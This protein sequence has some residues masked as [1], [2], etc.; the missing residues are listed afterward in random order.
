MG[1]IIEIDELKSIELDILK[2]VAKFCDENGLTYYL[3]Y[4]TLIG[5]VRHKGFIPWD[6]DIDIWM[7]RKD[8]N[9]LIETFNEKMSDT[10]YIAIYPYHEEAQH[11][12][13]KIGD[14]RTIKFEPEYK[15]KNGGGYIDIDVLPLDGT[16]D[17]EATHLAWCEKLQKN[18]N[19]FFY[20]RL[21]LKT[22]SFRGRIKTIIK[23]ILWG[24]YTRPKM[25]FHKKALELHE[26]Y[27]YENAKFIG[28]IECPWTSYRNRLNKEWFSPKKTQFED[29]EFNIPENYHEILIKLYGNYM[30]LPPENERIAWHNYNIYWRD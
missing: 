19:A 21:I 3:A 5:A 9:K 15:Y 8:Y 18:Y 4:G 16:P 7:P 27:P 14:K 11:T 17:D 26:Q 13:L 29:C 10:P 28:S 22:R 20:Q 24:C 6:D 23:K 30:T 25:Y 2:N 12:F 1:K